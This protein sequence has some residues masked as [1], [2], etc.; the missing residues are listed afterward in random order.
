MSNVGN[1]YFS[2]LFS[3]LSLLRTLITFQI[4]HWLLFSGSDFIAAQCYNLLQSAEQ[5]VVE[6]G[7]P[8]SLVDVTQQIVEHK[9]DRIICIPVPSENERGETEFGVNVRAY[10]LAPL[11]IAQA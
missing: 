6:V 5:T 1:V 3:L 8:T 11:F 2:L 9:P 4:M 7:L 10:L